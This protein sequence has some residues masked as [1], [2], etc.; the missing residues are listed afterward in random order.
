MSGED[1]GD[2]GNK[3][4]TGT[5]DDKNLF[6]HVVKHLPTPLPL[7]EL[8]VALLNSLSSTMRCSKVELHSC[9]GPSRVV[10]SWCATAASLVFKP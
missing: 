4:C 3:F 8:Q 6:N 1:Y 7:V 9:F 2:G 5:H 10:R